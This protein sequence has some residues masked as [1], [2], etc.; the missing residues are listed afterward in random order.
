MTPLSTLLRYRWRITF[1][2][3]LAAIAIGVGWGLV[4]LIE[5]IVAS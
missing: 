5:R 4:S 3:M 1:F 2:G